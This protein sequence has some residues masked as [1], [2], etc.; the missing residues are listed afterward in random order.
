MNCANCGAPM[1]LAPD[2][3]SYHCEYCKSIYFPE[4]TPD[5]IRFLEEASE[6]TCPVCKI[7]LLHAWIDETAALSCTRCRGILLEQ[8]AFMT[9][10]RYLRARSTQPAVQ[11]GP[12]RTEELERDI[13]CPYCR[14][15]M[16]THP[17]GGPGNIVVDNCAH[18][19]VIWLDS[20]EASR[21]VRAPGRDRGEWL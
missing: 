8:N 21:V 13:G 3:H 7:P 20:G 5:G 4:E 6:V 18:C 10:L 9:T 16:D 15:E 1:K 2:R 11:P 19:N 17:Y 14:K 12:M